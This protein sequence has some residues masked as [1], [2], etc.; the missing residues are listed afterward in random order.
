MAPAGPAV[1]QP[2]VAKHFVTW[3]A[4]ALALAVLAP[5]PARADDPLSRPPPPKPSATAPAT[6]PAA[7]ASAAPAP[8]AGP[9]MVQPRPPVIGDTP[10]LRLAGEE[11]V[12][13]RVGIRVAPP[14]IVRN[15]IT[16]FEGISIDLWE[17]VAT[18]LGVQTV[19]VLFDDVQSTLGALRNN[20]IDVVVAPL[21]VTRDRERVIDFSHS[22]ARSGLTL[23]SVPERK[24]DIGTSLRIVVDTLANPTSLFILAA[25]GGTTLS[26]AFLGWLNRNRY[27]GWEDVQNE[28]VPMRLAHFTLQ[29][30]LRSLAVESDVFSFRALHMQ[31]LSLLMLIFGMTVAASYIGLVSSALSESLDEPRILHLRDMAG[32][33]VG[34]LRGS[35]AEELLRQTAAELSPEPVILPEATWRASVEALIDGRSDL[36]LGD[37]LQLTYFARLPEFTGRISV[38]DQTFRFEPQAWGFPTGSPWRDPVN[39]ELIGVLRDPGWPQIVQRYLG[40]G[41][42]APH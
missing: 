2:R 25:I 19:Y 18:R 9:D 21:T 7:A 40:L 17:A 5:R 20:T 34:T 36:V 8:A 14:L 32:Q 33:R 31:I 1:T 16:G 24:F 35:T 12:T 37:W 10:V 41:V 3:L 11:P 15:E 4:L 42:T 22:Y 29:G 38:Q 6:T 23:A 27:G 26:F 28:P 39:T 13:L 30:L